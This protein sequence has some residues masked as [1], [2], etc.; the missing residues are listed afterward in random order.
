MYT[1]ESWVI[2]VQENAIA[3]ICNFERYVD[4]LQLIISK[5]QNFWASHSIELR[6]R[7]LFMP[8]GGTEEKWGG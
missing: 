5:Y 4:V 8:Q 2:G 3:Q 6:D 1:H 7:S